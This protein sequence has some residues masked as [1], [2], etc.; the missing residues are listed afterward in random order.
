MLELKGYDEWDF[1]DRY[2]RGSEGLESGSSEWTLTQA[3][4]QAQYPFSVSS[5]TNSVDNRLDDS[6]VKVNH[7]CSD[8]VTQC[9]NAETEAPNS[10]PTLLL[11]LR[12][13]RAL[14]ERSMSLS[15]GEQYEEQGQKNSRRWSKIWLRLS[16]QPTERNK[17]SKKSG[18]DVAEGTSMGEQVST[19]GFNQS[20][21]KSILRTR[22]RPSTSLPEFRSLY[23]IKPFSTQSMN[24]TRS[25]SER[26]PI[27]KR[28]AEEKSWD[29]LDTMPPS[30]L[31]HRRPIY[32]VP[33]L[34]SVP[35]LPLSTSMSSYPDGK[36]A[37]ETAR[38]I[39]M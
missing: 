37:S 14:K 16:R 33:R 18:E 26:P 6:E 1:I 2:A 3:T 10:P 21:W 28:P 5:S 31:F 25:N 4:D 8:R 38:D 23:E 39:K 13:K 36:R 24:H 30:P 12:R 32:S 35:S 7:R 15:G 22:H 17:Q 9:V 11:K 34:S 19:A 29:F 27:P 20:R